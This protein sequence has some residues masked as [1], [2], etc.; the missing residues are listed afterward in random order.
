MR[1][2]VLLLAVVVAGCAEPSAPEADPTPSEGQTSTPTSAGGPK[3]NS[4]ASSFPCEAG[5]GDLFLASSY[6]SGPIPDSWRPDLVEITHDGTIR[7]LRGHTEPGPGEM[8]AEDGALDGLTL[9]EA[10]AMLARRNFTYETEHLVITRGD[11]GKIP[12]ASYASFCQSIT[13]ALPTLKDDYPHKPGCSNDT[14]LTL[15]W[16]VS[17]AAGERTIRMSDCAERPEEF[18]KVK[19]D[20]QRLVGPG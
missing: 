5:E 15:T 4:G 20:F 16:H 3:S 11:E 8:R 7:I 9:D 18:E 13:D 1:L 12:A 2:A 14:A 17:T 10:A 19:R 6:G